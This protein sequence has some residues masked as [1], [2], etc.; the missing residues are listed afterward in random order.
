MGCYWVYLIFSYDETCGHIDVTTTPSPEREYPN[1]QDANQMYIGGTEIR[2]KN[3]M[4]GPPLTSALGLFRNT[5]V[6]CRQSHYT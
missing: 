1:F 6:E 5:S 3:N 2:L 4:G